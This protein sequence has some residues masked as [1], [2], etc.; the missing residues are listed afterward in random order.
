LRSHSHSIL[1]TCLLLVMTSH[2]SIVTSSRSD[3]FDKYLLKYGHEYGV[4]DILAL[5]GQVMQES[6]FTFLV[7]KENPCHSSISQPWSFGPLQMNRGCNP[8][9]S[10]NRSGSFNDS[11]WRNPDY[12]FNATISTWMKVYTQF[13]GEYLGCTQDTYVWWTVA[14]WN[15]G[16]PPSKYLGCDSSPYD[17]RSYVPS[18]M[19]D[20]KGLTI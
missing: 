5:K 11:M 19:N 4:P 1:L 3:V 6:D 10:S 20:E 13:K 18:V 12:Y 7:N 15:A 2:W 16:P 8:W 17:P 9:F 14:A